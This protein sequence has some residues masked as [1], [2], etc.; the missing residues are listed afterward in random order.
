MKI[1]AI[2]N[3]FGFGGA[4]ISTLEYFELMKNRVKLRVLVCEGADERFSSCINSLGIKTYK[5]PCDI[6]MGYPLIDVKSLSKLLE[7]ADVVWLTDVEY[8]VAPWIKSVRRISVIAHLHSY[9]LTCPWWGALYGF[10]KTCLQTCSPWRITRCKQG[11]NLELSRI[12]VQSSARAGL[13]WLLDFVKSPLDYIRWKYLMRDVLENIDGYIPVSNELW[14]IHVRHIPKLLEK[15]HVVIYNPVTEPLKHVKP[16]PDE[17][18]GDYIFYASGSNPVKGP[19][20]LLEAWKEVS[21]EYRDLK[22]YMVDCKGSWVE[23]IGRRKN[24]KNVVFTEKLPTREYYGLMY[25]A[26]AV[27]M[28]SIWPEPFGRIP[29]EANRLGVPAIVS[30]SGG[31]SELIENNVNGCVLGNVCIRELSDKIKIILQESFIRECIIKFINSKLN[32]NKILDQFVKF[33]VDIAR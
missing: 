1:L 16:D 10:R 33:L 20:L 26:R 5:A 15:P 3:S 13:Y 17:P 31:L 7:W 8:L 19:H 12:E 32:F 30:G 21:E 2:S 25:R 11:I 18:Y 23:R 14:R 29:V 9:A 28:P 27:V 6:V 4:Q 24:L 22:L